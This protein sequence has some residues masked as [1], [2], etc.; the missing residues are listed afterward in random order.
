MVSRVSRPDQILLQRGT[1]LVHLLP[2]SRQILTEELSLEDFS[3]ALV[4]MDLKIEAQGAEESS[5][6]I[7]PTQEAGYTYIGEHH[8]RCPHFLFAPTHC[9]ST[10]NAEVLCADLG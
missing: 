6:V 7:V 3:D 10:P 1:R 4:V 9:C 8:L 2:F 5:R